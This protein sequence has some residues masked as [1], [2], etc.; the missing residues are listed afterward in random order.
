MNLYLIIKWLHVL[1]GFW[2]VGGVIGRNF[3]F[4]R[5]GQATEVR[6]VHALLQISD[7]FERYAVIPV[8]IAVLLFGLIATFMQGWP[9]FGSLQG[10]P[11]NWLLVS[12]LL[13]VLLAGVMVPLQLPARRRKRD[14]ALE[15]AL[16]EN[17][18]TPQ[19]TAALNDK[20]VLNFRAVEFVILIAITLLMVTKP[21]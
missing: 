5:A 15:K 12:F 1:T 2:L 10:A 9:L 17:T 11:S 8:L 3:A 16:D 18:I 20:V 21:F 6:S 19:L 4:W 14:Y 13:F 7:F